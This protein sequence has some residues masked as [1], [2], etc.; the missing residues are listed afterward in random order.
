M[1]DRESR[2]RT[3]LEKLEEPDGRILRDSII[4]L[5]TVNLDRSINEGD[6]LPPFCTVSFLYPFSKLSRRGPRRF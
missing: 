4:R 2:L 6:P 1:D 5:V 3:A